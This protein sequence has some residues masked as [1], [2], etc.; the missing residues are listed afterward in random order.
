MSRLL[1]P[2]LAALGI[3]L[4]AP[5]H[6]GAPARSPDA[7]AKPSD[8]ELKRAR[9]ELDKAREELQRAA[10]RFAQMSMEANHDN[11]RARAWEYVT[12]PRRAMLGVMIANGPEKNGE[13]RGVLLTGVTPGSGADKAGL[14]SGDLLLSCNGQTLATK[15]RQRGGSERRLREIMGELKDGDQVKLDYEREGKRSAVTVTASRLEHMGEELGPMMGWNDDGDYMLPPVPPTPPMPP[16]PPSAPMAP[17][18]P[19]PPMPPLPPLPPSAMHFHES[20]GVE[21]AKLDANLAPYFHTDKGVLVV[22]APRSGSLGLKSGDVIQQVDGKPVTSPVD[23]LDRFGE[24]RRDQK[25]KVDIVRQGRNMNLEGTLP[26]RHRVVR[27][28][29]IDGPDGDDDED[30]DDE[31]GD[32]PKR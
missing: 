6:A 8:E 23:V 14:K 4:A 16:M 5:V 22:D 1:V 2:A 26:D 29:E 19:M 11:P 30:D 27:R 9:D 17:L 12:N 32:S 24:V 3:A 31:G 10:E 21:L 20:G 7:Q 15:P 25:V 13:I 18:P 28:I